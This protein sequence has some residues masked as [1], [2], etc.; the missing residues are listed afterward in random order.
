MKPALLRPQALRDRESEV[1]YYRR[2][3]GS[4]VAVRLVKATRR[5]LD[6]VELNPGIGSP[7]LGETLGIDGLK[8]WRVA[9]FPLLWCYFERGDCL[10]VVRLISGRQ[11]LVAVLGA[12]FSDR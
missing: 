8:T 5:A 2:E 7:T 10:D 12:E 1:R 11:D 4:S 9:R 3:A 6:Q